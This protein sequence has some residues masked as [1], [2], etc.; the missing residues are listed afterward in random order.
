MAMTWLYQIN[1]VSP[2]IL[3]INSNLTKSISIN[4]SLPN[5][6]ITRQWSSE[7]RPDNLGWIIFQLDEPKYILQK[8]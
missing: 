4:S 5:E 3:N 2:Q 8:I 7:K 6:F 1:H